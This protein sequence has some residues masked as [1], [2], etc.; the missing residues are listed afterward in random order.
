MN[1]LRPREV[2]ASVFDI[3]FEALRRLGMQAVVFDLDRTLRDPGPNHVKPEVLSLLERLT[4]SGLRVGILT[5]RHPAEEDPLHA[6]LAR[7]Y[8]LRLAARK[9][10]KA[11]FL[12]LLRE[13]DASPHQ[14]VMVGD[15]LLTD[16]FG[17]NRLGMY[18]IRVRPRCAASQPRARPSGGP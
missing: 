16:V 10:W 11:G 6:S 12:A 4:A 7:I 2:V 9:P 17:A 3:D 1:P 5:N 14:A 13:L 15:R 18:S 8:P